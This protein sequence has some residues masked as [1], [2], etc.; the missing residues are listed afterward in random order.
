MRFTVDVNM[1]Y[2]LKG[3]EGILLTLE[4][5]RA[6]GQ[7]VVADN[8]VISNA[9]VRVMDG[10]SGLGKRTWAFVEGDELQLSYSVQVDVDRQSIPLDS[11]AASP[12]DEL[13]S[14]VLT[15]LRPS[16]FCQSDL[17]TSFVGQ[18]FDEYSGGAK[19]NAMLNWV[20]AELAY[21]SGSSNAETTAIDTFVGRV[22]VCRDYAH[23]M[24][25]LA[26]AANIP[27]R[28]TSVY[29]VG[30]QPPDFHAVAEVWLGGAWHLVDATGMSSPEDTI[31]IGTGRDAA[32]VAFMET[33]RWVE[34]IVQ[35]VAVSSA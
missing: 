34:L 29:S 4:A 35:E 6:N 16:R 28:Y 17:F 10:E 22:G 23:L 20:G 21:V 5:A 33:E 27:A 30:V 32:D 24:C 9:T 26:R 14:E 2:G 1:K 3:Q 12:L 25:S 18:Q 15:Y 19:I 31:I 8:L 13:P 7:T 11:L